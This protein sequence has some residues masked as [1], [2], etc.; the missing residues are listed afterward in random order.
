MTKNLLGNDTPRYWQRRR[1]F[2][3]DN[4]SVQVRRCNGHYGLMPAWS[5]IYRERRRDRR[6]RWIGRGF[7][8][9]QAA[10]RWYAPKVDHFVGAVYRNTSGIRSL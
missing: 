2:G 1:P 6:F 10:A 3:R 8:P 7:L 4:V 5:L 9:R